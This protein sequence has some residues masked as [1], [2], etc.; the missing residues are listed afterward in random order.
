MNFNV[1]NLYSRIRKSFPTNRDSGLPEDPSPEQTPPRPPLFNQSASKQPQTTALRPPK[2][3]PELNRRRLLVFS[4]NERDGELKLQPVPHPQ[5]EENA[6]SKSEQSEN[7]PIGGLNRTE[8]DLQPPDSNHQQLVSPPTENHTR[9]DQSTG[10]PDEQPEEMAHSKI[11]LVLN[12]PEG[13]EQDLVIFEW[14]ADREKLSESERM[15]KLYNALMK[16]PFYSRLKQIIGAEHFASYSSMREFV[17]K[18]VRPDV[19]DMY[20]DLF[21]PHLADPL[22][23][24]KKAKILNSTFSDREIVPFLKKHLPADVYYQLTIYPF[25]TNDRTKL[26]L[27]ELLTKYV[28]Q[29][30]PL[31]LAR[32]SYER[33]PF[34]ELA[35]TRT[36]LLNQVTNAQIGEQQDTQKGNAV[37]E[38]K[39]L[40]ARVLEVNQVK[41]EFR[42]NGNSSDRSYRDGYKQGERDGRCNFHRRYRMKAEKCTGDCTMFDRSYYSERDGKGNWATPEFLRREAARPVQSNSQ[43][44][45]QST[46]AK[47][48]SMA[49]LCTVLLGLLK[50]TQQ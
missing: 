2:T 26:T 7:I 36:T 37:A 8:P 27:L 30:T 11:E 13:V 47:T 10:L 9:D 50:P 49:E 41:T 19:S 32:Q 44:S 29:S 20:G 4:P 18:N 21:S 46:A 33:G 39:E 31:H 40:L 35:A 48:D 25:D 15:V 38:I 14:L 28:Q 3:L 6:H 22:S 1:H 24:Y 42:Q 5:S 45:T 23:A 12:D 34:E 43:S 17:L 16:A